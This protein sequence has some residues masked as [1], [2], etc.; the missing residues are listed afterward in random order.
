M[1]LNEKLVKLLN[2]Q[3]NHERFNEAFYWSCGSYF[4]SLD[5]EN[6]GNY[7]KLHAKEEREHAERFYNFL[8]ENGERV[9]I[10]AVPA[11]AKDFKS[12]SQPFELAVLAEERTSQLIRD[13]CKL[14]LKEDDYRSLKFLKDFELEQ[15]EEEDLWTYNLSRA[16]LAEDDKAAILIIDHEMAQREKNGNKKYKYD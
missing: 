5:L 7:F 10:D 15:Q 2:Q 14:A 13:M 3:V 12:F 6:I 9:I 8:D 1:K 11:P 4:D 16:K